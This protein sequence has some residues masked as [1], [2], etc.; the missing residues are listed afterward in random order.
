MKTNVISL[1]LLLILAVSCKKNTI[2]EKQTDGTDSKIKITSIEGYKNGGPF[3]NYL[4][5]KMEGC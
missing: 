2:T 1:L 4:G 3:I 5:T